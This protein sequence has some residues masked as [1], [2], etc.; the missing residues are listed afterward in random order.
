VAT[1]DTGGAV[2]SARERLEIISAYQQT[3]SYR[4]AATLSGT[5]H[6]TVRRVVECRARRRRGPAPPAAAEEHRRR[7]RA[8]RR[9]GARDRR[10]HLGKAPLAGSPGGR[11][12]GFGAQ[13]AG[14]GGRDHDG[15]P[16]S[17]GEGKDEKRRAASPD[18]TGGSPR[19]AEAPLSALTASSPRLRYVAH[20]PHHRLPVRPPDGDV[21]GR[22]CAQDV[23][24]PFSYL[25]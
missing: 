1:H 12:R 21:T 20:D 17:P 6:K 7:A 24:H 16:E 15:G 10:A 19:A 11:R 2:K 14:G 18:A 13:R 3:G 9:A 5:T 25:A 22:G 23:R 8:G 4:A